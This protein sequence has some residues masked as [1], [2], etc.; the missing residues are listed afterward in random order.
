MLEI[1][2]LRME[3]VFCL[4]LSKEVIMITLALASSESKWL[5]YIVITISL[6]FHFKAKQ[7]KILASGCGELHCMRRM[8]EIGLLRMEVVFCLLFFQKK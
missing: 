2:L 7:S 8:L 3:V 1:G 4:F 6:Q 5:F